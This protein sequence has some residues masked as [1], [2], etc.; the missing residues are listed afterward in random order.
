MCGRFSLS[1]EKNVL[2]EQYHIHNSFNFSPRYNLTPGQ[3]SIVITKDQAREMTWGFVPC[4]AK[5]PQA[6]INARSDSL[7]KP[8]FQHS[9]RKKRCLIPA[10]GFFEWKVGPAKKK[11]PYRLTLKEKAIFS[12]AGL[13]ETRPSS[14]GKELHTFAIITTEAKGRLKEIH[15]RMPVILNPKEEKIW[16]DQSRHNDKN[17]PPLF[18]SFS[19]EK[20]QVTKVS[21]LVNSYLND[22]P[23]CFRA[24][25]EHEQ[26]DLFSH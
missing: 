24:H 3:E 14:Q 12:F 22:S 25:T 9:F 13:W 20:I 11:T 8:T 15:P 5:K 10:C 23:Q 18:S 26:L 16:M 4:W 17:L 2:I 6:I 19:S 1:V 21:P 7:H